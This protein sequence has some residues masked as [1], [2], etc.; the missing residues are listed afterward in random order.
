MRMTLR[1][2][3]LLTSVLFAVCAC[4]TAEPVESQFAP[5]PMG[6]MAAARSM[7]QDTFQVT[8]EQTF[9]RTWNRQPEGNFSVSFLITYSVRAGQEALAE[10]CVKT[11]WATACEGVPAICETHWKG[12]P[13]C[14]AS[15]QQHLT[16]QLFPCLNGAPVATV[17]HIVWRKFLVQ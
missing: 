6:E 2:L 5:A 9:E 1:H 11:N 13:A 8:A 7:V 4:K 12:L 10:Q 3:V 17:T 15:L 16:E 14:T